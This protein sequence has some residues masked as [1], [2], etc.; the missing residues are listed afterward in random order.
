MSESSHA[1]WRSTVLDEPA[2][3]CPRCR[4]FA[5][6]RSGFVC[7]GDAKTFGAFR[8]LPRSATRESHEG[9]RII[10]AWCPGYE[11]RCTITT[12]GGRG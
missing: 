11:R 2:P 6:R 5:L 1:Q 8:N 10:P 4:W 12:G 7:L 3:N 9:G